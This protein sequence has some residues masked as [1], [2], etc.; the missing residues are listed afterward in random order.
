MNT[1]TNGSAQRAEPPDDGGE[2]VIVVFILVA[3]AIV[4]LGGLV[5]LVLV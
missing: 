4:F 5:P 3:L 2:R 1:S